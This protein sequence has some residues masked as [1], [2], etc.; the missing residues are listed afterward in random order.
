[1]V[2]SKVGGL[3][4]EKVVAK[5]L[6][7]L[8]GVATVGVTQRSDSEQ[9]ASWFTGWVCHADVMQALAGCRALPRKVREGTSFFL[10]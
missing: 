8:L 3:S 1:M 10:W 2:Q 9:M 7:I 6:I 4:Q 5:I